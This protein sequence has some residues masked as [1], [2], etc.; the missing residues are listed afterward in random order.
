MGDTIDKKV[1]DLAKEL[2]EIASSAL[3]EKYKNKHGAANPSRFLWPI[4]EYVF[5][6]EQSPAEYVMEMWNGEW[7]KDPR[8]LLEWSE[9]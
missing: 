1:L 8:K 4:K 5:I 6:R 9:K 7:H 2:L 3:K